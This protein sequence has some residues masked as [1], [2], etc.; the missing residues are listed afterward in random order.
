MP[1]GVFTALAEAADFVGENW[2]RRD[3]SVETA[4]IHR[5]ARGEPCRS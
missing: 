2:P 4:R 5:R 1:D 3:V